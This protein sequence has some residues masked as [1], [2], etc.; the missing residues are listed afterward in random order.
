M[1]MRVKHIFGLKPVAVQPPA[2]W[3]AEFRPAPV[4]TKIPPERVTAWSVFTLAAL[5]VIGVMYFAQTI[6]LP[7][8]A[9]AVAAVIASP[10]VRWL[11]ARHLPSAVAA[12]LALLGFLGVLG[13]IGLLMAPQ[14]QQ[15]GDRLP[16]MSARIEA[17][18]ADIRAPLKSLQEAKDK[19]EKATEVGEDSERPKVSVGRSQ[20]LGGGIA[21]IGL[22]VGIFIVLTFFFLTARRDYRRRLILSRGSQ[23]ERLRAA[24][25][26]RDMSNRVSTYLFTVTAINVG[27]GIIT[28]ATLAA[29]GMPGA[30]LI[31]VAIAL[32]NFV[33]F[34]G[35]LIVILGTAILALA[36]FDSWTYILLPTGI[37]LFY[38]LLESQIVSPWLV[39]RRLEMSPIAVFIGI[40]FLG[41]LWGVVGAMIAVPLLILLYTFGQHI[42]V[43]S[44]LASLIGPTEGETQEEAAPAE[45]PGADIAA[46]P[47]AAAPATPALSP[48]ALSPAAVGPAG[49]SPL[50]PG[51]VAP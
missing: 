6:I 18:L 45:T 23:S 29:V 5:A 11:E 14:F 51:Q 32:F 25:I 30:V 42:P 46:E 13:G 8:A 49:M 43:L 36:T 7:I 4:D 50:L 28:G 21:E 40:A 38:H 26:V 48:A 20:A 41:W 1:A 15:F 37:V 19:L 17:K 12:L 31:G 44:P 2:D 10:A 34:I 35:S 33:P 27:L 22:Q 39:G 16:E 9:A 3:M 47:A 24:R